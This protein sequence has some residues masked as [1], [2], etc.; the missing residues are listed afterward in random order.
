M[1]EFEENTH[2]PDL[3]KDTHQYQPSQTKHDHKPSQGNPP[4]A[5]NPSNM[6]GRWKPSSRGP[7]K[8]TPIK[9]EEQE[10]AQPII[11][12]HLSVDEDFSDEEEPTIHEEFQEEPIVTK[13]EHH[14]KS[15]HTPKE[16]PSKPIDRK[17]VFI[18]KT[19]EESER[20][21]TRY[22]AMG[23][24]KP[25]LW[26]KILSFF[27]LGPKSK[28]HK[29]DYKGSHSKSFSQKRKH[30]QSKKQSGPRTTHPYKHAPRK[31][32]PKSNY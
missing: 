2:N 24:K 17:D 14:I 21:K 31:Q 1:P 9:K 23:R 4:S 16:K 7:V 32:G 22:P 3:N 15:Q 12:T 6:R 28:K 11:Q 8:H 29:D 20:H 27:G 26:Q 25:S 18:P 19:K 10:L 13:R 30:P 5:S